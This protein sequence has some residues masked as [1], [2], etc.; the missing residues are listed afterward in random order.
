M[1]ACL[2]HAKQMPVLTSDQVRGVVF[3]LFGIVLL[4]LSSAILW[5]LLDDNPKAKSSI[6]SPADA[7]KLVKAVKIKGR[8]TM[9]RQKRNVVKS[10]TTAWTQWSG[11]V[12]P[13]PSQALPEVKAHF[14]T[15]AGQAFDLSDQGIARVHAYGHLNEVSLAHPALAADFD[16]ARCR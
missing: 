6:T 9:S 1:L 8:G 7:A 16:A 15:K 14:R 2:V 5:R 11:P 4:P 10:L 3:N 12:P 13:L